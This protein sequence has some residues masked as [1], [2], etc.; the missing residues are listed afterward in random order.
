M[1][2][3][4]R[5]QSQDTE[6]FES[7]SHRGFS[8]V[9]SSV[10]SK[11]TNGNNI[12]DSSTMVVELKSPRSGRWHKASGGAQRNPR[13]LNTK[14][15]WSPIAVRSQNVNR[16]DSAVGRSA[17]FDISNRDPGVPLRSTPGSMLSTASR[18]LNRIRTLMSQVCYC[19]LNGF[20]P[21][22]GANIALKRRCE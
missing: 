18:T 6:Q 3:S 4:S 16:Y 19:R 12:L 15:L 9:I 20:S 5:N 1:Q 11:E 2:R 21:L 7:H 13:I 8:P 22:L 10:T 17:C 14:S